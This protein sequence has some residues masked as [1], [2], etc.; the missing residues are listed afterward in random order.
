MHKHPPRALPRSAALAM[1]FI[2]TMAGPLGAQDPVGPDEDDPV[3]ALVS[4][5]E[6]LLGEGHIREPFRLGVVGDRRDG[7][8][9]ESTERSLAWVAAA[10]RLLGV[11][12]DDP[13]TFRRPTCDPDDA[14]EPAVGPCRW[15]NP[16]TP[17]GAHVLPGVEGQ[18]EGV[19]LL[20]VS[21]WGIHPEPTTLRGELRPSGWSHHYTLLVIPSE[22]GGPT[23][24]V[25]NV[26]YG[27]WG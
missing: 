12:V 20:G 16:G 15:L 1:G 10:S 14:A 2:V 19:R 18:G 24:E 21:I 26:L 7:V 17:V 3:P 22:E 11:P 8:D 5:I 6:F 4:A 23:I 13:G 27:S 9:D 25:V